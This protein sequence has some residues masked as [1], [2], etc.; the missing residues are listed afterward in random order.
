M[1]D[2]SSRMQADDGLMNGE[3]ETVAGAPAPLESLAVRA[4]DWPDA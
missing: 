1:T 3:R 2:F 4:E